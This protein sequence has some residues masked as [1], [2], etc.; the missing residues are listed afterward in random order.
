[1]YFKP[2]IQS[3]LSFSSKWCMVFSQ[4]TQSIL[5]ITYGYQFEGKIYKGSLQRENPVS[6]MTLMLTVISNLACARWFEDTTRFNFRLS[7]LF[8]DPLRRTNN[9]CWT[10]IE[11]LVLFKGKNGDPRIPAVLETPISDNML[12]IAAKVNARQVSL[13]CCTN[14]NMLA[15]IAQ[16]IVHIINGY[17]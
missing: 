12:Q 11:V 10:E 2:L 17:N 14:W 5:L 7:A 3:G 8:K 15:L 6:I 13:L 16:Q 4:G 9:C 1:M